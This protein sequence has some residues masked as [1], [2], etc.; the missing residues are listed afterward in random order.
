MGRIYMFRKSIPLKWFVAALLLLATAKLTAQEALRA[1]MAGDLAAAS[2]KQAQNTVGHYNL[3]WGPVTLR[4]SS[5]LSEQ[6]SDH[7]GNS[8]NGSSDLI[9]RPSANIQLNWPV[10]E[11]NTL[12]LSLD[13][14]YSFYSQNSALDQFFFNPGS[15]LSFDIY[16]GSWVIDLHDRLT[17][18]ENS[19]NNPTAHEA[20]GTST[21]QNDGGVSGMWDLNKLVVNVGYDHVNYMNLGQGGASQPDSSTE[22]LSINTGV[23]MTP[24]IMVGPEVG[25]TLVTYDQTGSALVSNGTQWSAGAFSSFQ[26]SEHLSLRL[27]GGFTDYTPETTKTNLNQ[28]MTGLYFQLS[29]SHQV[30]E[31]VSYTVSAGRSI[32]FSYNGLYDRLFFTVSPSWLII[33]DFAFSTPLSWEQDTRSGTSYSQWSAGFL[34]GHPITK[35]LSASLSYQWIDET[36]NQANYSY[37]ANIAGLNFTYQF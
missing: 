26:V 23:R 18:S 28:T 9:T 8:A 2:R 34:V 16:I 24:T 30:N 4:A 1:S 27:D 33:R 21:F 36:S 17:M 32:D 13:A 35:K 15:G 37:T 5:G 19:Y 6:Y 29:L 12:N 10:T 7:A 31:H 20:Q 3:M 11:Y 22:N 14:G 25:G